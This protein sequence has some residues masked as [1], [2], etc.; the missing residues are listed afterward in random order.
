MAKSGERFIAIG[1]NRATDGDAVPDLNNAYEGASQDYVAGA[2]LTDDGAGN[3]IEALRSVTS[4]TM[5]NLG[6]AYTSAPTV[7]ATLRAA[8]VSVTVTNGGSNYIAVPAITFSGSGG[9][10]ATA[11]V[12]HNGKLTQIIVTTPGVYSSVPTVTITPATNPDGTTGTGAAATAV[13][14]GLSG[15]APTFTARVNGSVVTT[16]VTAAGSGYTSVPGVT[17][18][19]PNIAGGIQATGHVTLSTTTVGAVVI[20]NPGTGYTSPPTITI[21]GG[22]GTG[23]TAT[24]TISGALY[25]VVVATPGSKL[26]VA[27]SLA[28][29]GGAGSGAAGTAVIGLSVLTIIGL[30]AENAHNDAVAGTHRA[31]VHIIRGYKDEFEGTFNTTNLAKGSV[32]YTEVGPARDPITKRHYI[33]TTGS[34]IVLDSFPSTWDDGDSYPTVNFHVRQSLLKLA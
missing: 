15:V 19:A 18:S 32:R 5:T 21:A 12:D 22:G 24:C 29:S 31:L 7:T 3:L 30:A 27:P 6:S 33:A 23:A 9:G 28:F 17:F 16:T 10:A 34:G 25:D 8:M 13:L 4:V 20:D 1:P 14:D 26:T 2:F 11:V